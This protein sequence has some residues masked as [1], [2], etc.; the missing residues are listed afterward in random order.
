MKVL[1]L[2]YKLPFPALDGG[3]VSL[4][5]LSK[6]LLSDGIDVRI[7]AM[8]QFNES[9]NECEKFQCFMERT[10][11]KWVEVDNRPK[12]LS[13]LISL[14]GNS[15]YLSTRFRC[16]AFEESLVKILKEEEFDVVELDHLYLH[17]Y[18][19][20]IRKHSKALVVLRAQNAEGNLWTQ[21]LKA[22]INPI[23]RFLLS[24]FTKRLIKEEL[25][26]LADVDLTFAISDADRDFFAR[27]CPDAKVETLPI[28]IEAPVELNDEEASARGLSF[29]HIGSMDWLPNIRGIKWFLDEVYPK[30]KQRGSRINLHFA[31]K[32]MP[33]WMH[34]LSGSANN[35]EVSGQV[36]DAWCFHRKHQVLIVPVQ[37][38]GGVRV[39]I[40]EAM[41][42][43]NVVVSTVAGAQGLDVTH[44]KE[45]LISNTADDFARY[46]KMLESD[47]VMR[48]DLSRNARSFVIENFSYKKV[49]SAF[50]LAIAN[51]K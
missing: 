20:T 46:M 16:E 18:I 5:E 38:S 15:S 3:A 6:A 36:A 42:A 22:E 17:W 40:L 30:I 31:G 45:M 8:K 32:R 26:T 11:L 24:I 10:N 39:K 33:A 21:N 23:K 13:M 50:R 51:T 37:E 48:R 29:Y 7:L 43:G 28:P 9:F 14:F 4:L 2:Y 49:A 34:R 19:S 27:F 44:G 41:M 12:A 35:I 25:R 47:P 1:Q